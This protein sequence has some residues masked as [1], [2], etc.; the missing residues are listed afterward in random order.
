MT[1]LET[2]CWVSWWKNTKKRSAIGEVM[3]HKYSDTSF[4]LTVAPD[5]RFCITLCTY[6]HSCLTVLFWA[7]PVLATCL[8]ISRDVLCKM[9][10]GGWPSWLQLGQS[11][12]G[13]HRSSATDS[14]NK[15]S[16]SLYIRYP[17]THQYP[18][19]KHAQT[20]TSPVYNQLSYDIFNNKTHF[21]KCASLLYEQLVWIWFVLAV[22]DI[23]GKFLCLQSKI[24]ML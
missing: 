18:S 7:E 17:T 23:N 14:S 1:S 3:G 13:P 12:I 11:I 5:Q 2:D 21:K 6:T 24:L 19:H 20:Q 9:L 8:L 15:G 10:R 4:Q 22:F 16:H